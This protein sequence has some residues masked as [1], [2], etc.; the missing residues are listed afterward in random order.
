MNRLDDAALDL[1]F[2]K[3]RRRNGWL[4]EEAA[5]KETV[6]PN[7]TL[8]AAYFMIAARAFGRDCG[9][10]SGFNQAKVTVPALA[11]TDMR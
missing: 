9:P 10:M 4:G 3:A 5:V 2:R 11:A 1:I 6:L 8:Q 7:A